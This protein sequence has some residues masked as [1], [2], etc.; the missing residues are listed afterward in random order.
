MPRTKLL[1]LTDIEVMAFADNLRRIAVS[2]ETGEPIKL[3]PN[4]KLSR[5]RTKK[6]I[7]PPLALRNHADWLVRKL[8]HQNGGKRPIMAWD[9]DVGPPPRKPDRQRVDL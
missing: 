6:G 9:N 8:M 5:T 3:F 4:K 2:I 7:N 1:S